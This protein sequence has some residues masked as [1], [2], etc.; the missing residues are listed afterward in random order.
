LPAIL[1]GMRGEVWEV[2]SG[3]AVEPVVCKEEATGQADR[4]GVWGEEAE[5]A[6]G[7]RSTAHAL[8]VHRTSFSFEPGTKPGRA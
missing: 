8:N 1:R 7:W 4:E 5:L 3:L 2:T 6:Q